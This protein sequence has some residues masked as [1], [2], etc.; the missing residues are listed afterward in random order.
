MLPRFPSKTGTE[1]LTCGT[2]ILRISACLGINA[3]LSASSIAL[4]ATSPSPG[5]TWLYTSSVVE[6]LECLSTSETIFGCTPFVSRSVA[7]V[8]LRSWK[9]MFGSPARLRSGF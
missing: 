4:P 2:Q 8:C 1:Q 9:R 7:Q 3:F 5:L 6:T